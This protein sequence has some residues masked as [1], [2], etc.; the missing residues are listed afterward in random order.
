MTVR[1]PRNHHNTLE[2]DIARI[3]LTFHDHEPMAPRR[4]GPGSPE[5]YHSH[6][7]QPRPSHSFDYPRRRSVAIQDLLNPVRED[8]RSAIHQPEQHLDY[9]G[10]DHGR[11]S[12]RQSSIDRESL[13]SA[14]SRTSGDHRSPPRGH[15]RREFRPTYTE[16]EVHFIWYHRVDLGWEWKEVLNAFHSQFPGRLRG[17][18]GI[19]CKYY[20]HLE[21][22]GIPQV[23]QRDRKA[24]ASQEYGIRARTGLWYPW[25]R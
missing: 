21:G 10:S 1:Y 9:A 18:S 2:S 8:N 5:A 14:Q 11:S 7:S 15:G 23:R 24:M 4:H 12:S 3:I 6:G 19:Q 16:E 22:H 17:A 13:V 25:M 20:R